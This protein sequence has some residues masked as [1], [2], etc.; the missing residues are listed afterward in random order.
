MQVS[1]GLKNF[2]CGILFS[3]LNLIHVTLVAADFVS[4][5]LT[6]QTLLQTQ[7]CNDCSNSLQSCLSLALEG[8]THV[9]IIMWLTL[10][11]LSVITTKPMRGR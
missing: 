1:D 9:R 5:I 2:I 3:R 11:L 7:F 8:T 4:H 10:F 6:G